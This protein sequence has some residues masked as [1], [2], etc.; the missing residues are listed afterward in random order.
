VVI[1]GDD[2]IARGAGTVRDMVHNKDYEGL[3]PLDASGADAAR[4]LEG[5]D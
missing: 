2:E 4:I 3:L 1:V 5:T